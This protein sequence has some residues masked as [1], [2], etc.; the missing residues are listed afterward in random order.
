MR[1]WTRGTRAE[2]QRKRDTVLA[3]TELTDADL[4]AMVS[5]YDLGEFRG[6]R[7]FRSGTV[8]TNVLVRTSVSPFALR[9]YENRSCDSAR[10]EVNLLCYLKKRGFPC[11]APRRNRRGGLVGIHRGKPF[12][13]F[14][15]VEGVHVGRLNRAQA[16]QVIRAVARLHALTRKYRPARKAARWNYD[17]DFCRTRAKVRADGLGD[18]SALAKLKWHGRQ[19]DRLRLPRSLPKGICHGDLNPLNMLFKGDTLVALIDFD[20]ANHTYLSFDLVGLLE[21]WAW[22]HEQELCLARAG[23]IAREY[24]SHRSMTEIEKKHVFDVHRLS[25][26][27]DCLWYFDRGDANSFF[28]RRKIE[29]LD[30]LGRAGYYKALFG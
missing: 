18:R 25:I 7:L 14:E 27:I 9:Y 28:E 6:S 13:L 12:A 26:L 17:V 8:Q 23:E 30:A 5:H 10:F 29:H 21:Y 24:S 4:V 20:D 3:G 1:T 16:G 15:F 11:S 2:R 19:L 22:P